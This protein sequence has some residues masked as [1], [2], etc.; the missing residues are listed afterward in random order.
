[1]WWIVPIILFVV[2][3]MSLEKNYIISLIK[4][5]AGT[6]QIASI[7]LAL[8]EQESSFNPTLLIHRPPR[9]TSYGLFQ[10]NISLAKNDIYEFLPDILID[11]KRLKGDIVYQIDMARESVNKLLSMGYS[12]EEIFHIW[13]RGLNAFRAGQRSPFI[14]LYLSKFNKWSRIIV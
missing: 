2:M 10:F 7:L 11:V 4:N 1:M 14:N 12:A 13:N 5:R 8:A 9:E 3:I 6:P